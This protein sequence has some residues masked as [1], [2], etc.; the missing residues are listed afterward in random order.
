MPRSDKYFP[1]PPRFS[2]ASASYSS[3]LPVFGIVSVYLPRLGM[4][5]TRI[6]N[7]AVQGEQREP[8]KLSQDY[9][10]R[11]WMFQCFAGRHG[12]L[13]AL[14]EIISFRCRLR[15]SAGRIHIL[16]IPVLEEDSGSLLRPGVW[17]VGMLRL[18]GAWYSA[19]IRPNPRK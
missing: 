2:K 12:R 10:R 15:L 4:G 19:H 18:I 5:A 9:V 6:S 3:N 14:C 8:W 7:G 1:L 13:A 16:S 17:L 11:V